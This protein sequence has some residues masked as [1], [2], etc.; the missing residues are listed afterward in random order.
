M[1]RRVTFRVV[2]Q[3]AALSEG[4]RPLTGL[5][6]SPVPFPR[7]S[8]PPPRSGA[9][10]PR[11]CRL[12]AKN[13]VLGGT[14]SGFTCLHSSATSARPFTSRRFSV[15]RRLGEQRAASTQLGVERRIFPPLP[16]PASAITDRRYNADRTF[17]SGGERTRR[18]EK[19]KEAVGERDARNKG[20]APAAVP[21]RSNRP[22]GCR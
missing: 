2:I 22:S 10:P 9:P 11:T 16:A 1:G 12:L 4:A 8:L 17:F 6:F 19:E 18:S 20:G 21:L 5:P 15:R 13:L 3:E 14:C 7:F